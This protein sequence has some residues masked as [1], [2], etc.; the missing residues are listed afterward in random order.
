[1]SLHDAVLQAETHLRPYLNETPLL[2]SPL[3]ENVFVKLETL[4]PTGSFK[5]RGALNKLLS[6][7]AEEQAKGVVAASTGNHGAAVAYALKKLELKGVVF[8]PKNAA[9]TKVEAIKRLGGEVR[10]YGDDGVVAERQARA[11]AAEHKLTYV[12]PYNDLEVVAGQGTVGVE[13][14][15]QLDKIDAVLIAL[16][17][18][19][20]ASGVAAYLKTVRP[21][22]EIIACSPENSA[23]MMASVQAGKIVDIPSLPTLSDGTAGGVE[24]GAVTFETVRNLVDDYVTVSEEEIKA[25]MRRFIELHHMLLEGAAGVVVAAYQKL[26]E[27]LAGKNVVLVICGANI[28]LADLRVVLNE[29]CSGQNS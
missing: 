8:V 21:S 19:G 20:L 12:S 17:G 5:V 4:Q 25:A 26:Q 24:A 13:L 16:G 10:V 29:S 1:M 7:H 6:L 28:G 22:V 3:G 9:P 14:A 15:R 11:Y 2:P 27:R 23:V 18:G